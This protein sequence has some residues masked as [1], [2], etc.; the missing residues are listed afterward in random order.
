MKINKCQKCGGERVV[1]I[2]GRYGQRAMCQAC[3]K[4]G[5]DR[6]GLDASIKAWNEGRTR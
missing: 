1:F 3:G 6:V 4:K 2:P 5:P